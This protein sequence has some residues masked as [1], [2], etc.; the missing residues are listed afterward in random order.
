MVASVAVCITKHELFAH[1][2]DRL[3]RDV[4]QHDDVAIDVLRRGVIVLMAVELT[5]PHRDDLECVRRAHKLPRTSYK[6]LRENDIST[7]TIASLSL[8]TP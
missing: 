8:A 4:D 1:E 5:H 7:S 2:R 6:A 3:Q